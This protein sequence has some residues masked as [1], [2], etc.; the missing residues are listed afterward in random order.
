MI[1]E[2]DPWE[3]LRPIMVKMPVEEI[4]RLIGYSGRMAYAMKKGER[5]PSRENII[6]LLSVLGSSHPGEKPETPTKS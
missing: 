3:E 4:M 1:Y 5:R 2:R 6:K